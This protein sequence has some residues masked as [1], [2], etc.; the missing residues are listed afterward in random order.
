MGNTKKGT[1]TRTDILET[2]V[3]IWPNVTA[4]EI[5]RQLGLKHPAIAYYFGANLQDAV[6]DYAV[7]TGN[8]CVIVQL[9][10]TKHRAVR[11]MGALERQKHMDAI[12]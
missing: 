5:A 2:G 3:K 7:E 11:K 12:C 6:A 8:S 10:A 1:K 9:I 4:S